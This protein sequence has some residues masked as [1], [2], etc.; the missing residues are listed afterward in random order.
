MGNEKLPEYIAPVKSRAFAEVLEQARRAAEFDSTILLTGDTGVGKEIVARYIHD[1]SR[2][3]RRPILTIN[4]AALPA[5]LLESELFGHKAGSFT[6]A[7]KDRVGLFEQAAQGTIFLD[8]IG[9]VSA[10]IQVKLLRVL[11][12]REIL[13][14]GESTP[15][16]VDIRVIAATNTDLYEAVTAKRFRVDLF[17]R[18]RVIEINVPPLSERNQ[19]IL[20]LADYI[21]ARLAERMQ[22]PR[23]K[24]DEACHPYLLNYRWP[25]NVR[26]LHNVMERAMVFSRGETIRAENL[27]PEIRRPDLYDRSF[28]PQ[29]PR[30]LK[31]VEA[32]HIRRILD[33]TRGNRQ[34]AARILGISQ[35]TLW[36][37]LKA[38]QGE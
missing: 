5:S 12:E 28:G 19:D 36:R 20:P 25:G 11:Q 10:A 14:I 15:R 8:E 34:H 9:E 1:N 24:L 2:R 7:V 26:E 29:V 30:S 21:L 23:L 4:C 32:A 35:S 37:K 16:R 27:P 6:G 31:E 3:C 13:R 33:Y 18:L 38:L 22:L 17:F